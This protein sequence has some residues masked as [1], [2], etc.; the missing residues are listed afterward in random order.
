MNFSTT[1]IILMIGLFGFCGYSTW[2]SS[3]VEY[4][5]GIIK[6]QHEYNSWLF[7]SHARVCDTAN[8][9]L[10]FSDKLVQKNEKL[11]KELI[12]K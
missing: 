6:S 9:L 3:R 7:H 5:K 1:E 10:N 11:N 12:E 2:L 8:Q 4:Y